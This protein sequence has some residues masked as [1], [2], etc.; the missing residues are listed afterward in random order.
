MACIDPH[1]TG[2][3][4]KGSDH[5]QLIKF[6]PSRAPGKGSA[7]GDFFFSALLQPAHSVCVSLSAFFVIIVQTCHI[8]QAIFWTSTDNYFFLSNSIRT[9][10]KLPIQLSLFHHFCIFC[11]LLNISDG[12]DTSRNTFTAVDCI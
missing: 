11:L 9:L 8:W 2:F 5:L 1:Q 6:W 7:G 3:V 4:G 12:N 10:S